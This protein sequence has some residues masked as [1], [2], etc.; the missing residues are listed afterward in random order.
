MI[1]MS[2]SG[3]DWKPKLKCWLAN[4][5]LEEKHTEPISNLFTKAFDALWKYAS[6]NLTFVMNILQVLDVALRNP[7]SSPPG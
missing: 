4:H 2:A 1:Y 5:A 7:V 6:T 3:L